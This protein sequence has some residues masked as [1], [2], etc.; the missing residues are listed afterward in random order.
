MAG[1]QKGATA[2][3]FVGRAK[4]W[5]AAHGID[6]RQ[7]QPGARSWGPDGNHTAASAAI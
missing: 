4:V 1:A 5:F 2:A 3:A 6:L 7:Q